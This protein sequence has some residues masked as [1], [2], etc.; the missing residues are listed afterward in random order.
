MAGHMLLRLRLP[1]SR[2]RFYASAAKKYDSTLC[3]P[4]TTFPM[5]ADAVKREVP[6]Q[7]IVAQE[8]YQWQ[9]TENSAD[10]PYVMHDGPPYANGNCQR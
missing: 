5:R 10:K 9:L 3:L 4:K 2:V 6:L 1:P 7:P 8:L